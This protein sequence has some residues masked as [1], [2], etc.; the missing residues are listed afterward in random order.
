MKLEMSSGGKMSENSKYSLLLLAA[1]LLLVFVVLY[2][3]QPLRGDIQKNEAELTQAQQR[4]A[5]YQ[6]FAEQNKNYS[7]FVAAQ[8]ARLAEAKKAM[9]DTVAVPVL[10]QEYADL[11]KTSGIQFQSV[12]PPT[13]K[14]KQNSGAYEIP[15]NITISGN[16]YKMVDFLQRVENGTRFSKLLKTNIS[17]ESDNSA[18]AADGNV[19][20]TAEF[21]VYSLK[22][23]LSA[24]SARQTASAEKTGTARV[25]ERDA[26]NQAEL[27]SV[28]K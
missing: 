18:K 1:V 23:S 25:K 5:S 27:G 3:V 26:A 17:A 12:E 19:K 9:P 28:A 15:L 22:D 11:S 24:A 2:I 20:I 6:T 21:T 16:Y 13:G 4:L 7:A 10:V 14:L 8:D